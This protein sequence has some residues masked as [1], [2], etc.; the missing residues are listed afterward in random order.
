M[1]NHVLEKF[2][3]IKSESREMNQGESNELLESRKV[4]N[5]K[6]IFK[7]II[8]IKKIVYPVNMKPKH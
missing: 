5:F 3:G 6:F 2:G 7:W 1:F 4:Q 8:A